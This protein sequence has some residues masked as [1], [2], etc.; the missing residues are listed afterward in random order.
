[1]KAQN[2]G[3]RMSNVG[4]QTGEQN[5][6]LAFAFMVYMNRSYGSSARKVA[7]DVWRL[8]PKGYCCFNSFYQS[9]WRLATNYINNAASGKKYFS[10]FTR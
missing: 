9:F 1:M 3:L 2:G 6:M 8:Y 4:R 10:R 7:K 5:T